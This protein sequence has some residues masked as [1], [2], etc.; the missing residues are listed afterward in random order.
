MSEL[1]KDEKI[2]LQLTSA[3]LQARAGEHLKDNDL[4]E[5][6]SAYR[7]LHKIIAS[8]PESRA[9]RGFSG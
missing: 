7:R 1:S 5:A 2:A 8:S 4:S 9:A 3:L 6:Y